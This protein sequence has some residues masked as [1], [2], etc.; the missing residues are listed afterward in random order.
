MCVRTL[1]HTCTHTDIKYTLAVVNVAKCQRSENTIR[2][3]INIYLYNHTR[4]DVEA[5]VENPFYGFMQTKL[6]Y[7]SL[8][9]KMRIT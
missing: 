8:W 9:L 6:Y 7:G 1:L 2:Y 4:C 5:Y 3:G